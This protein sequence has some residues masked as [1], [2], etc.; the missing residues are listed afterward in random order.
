MV[1]IMLFHAVGKEAP[2][3]DDQCGA[4]VPDDEE[5]WKRAELLAQVILAEKRERLDGDA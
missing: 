5:D 4:E 3:H 2:R 1:W